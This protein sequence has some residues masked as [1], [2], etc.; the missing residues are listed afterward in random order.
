[1]NTLFDRRFLRTTAWAMLVVWVFVLS[2]GVANACLL[3]Q[4]G[5]H[6]H[7]STSGAIAAEAS[8]VHAGHRV[9]RVA[10]GDHPEQRAA[11]AP[12]LK[13]CDDTPQSPIKA[14]STPNFD[15][16]ALVETYRNPWHVSAVLPGVGVRQA[17][18]ARF[19]PTGPPPRVAFSRL[20]L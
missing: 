5:A 1:M 8:S 7:A 11:K 10:D 4:P 12:C 15:A 13:V 17:V 3:E 18:A 6:R 19:V 14:A 9:L 16:P 2:V 20:V